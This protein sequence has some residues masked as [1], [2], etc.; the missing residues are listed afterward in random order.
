VVKRIRAQHN[1][2]LAVCLSIGT[3]GCVSRAVLVRLDPVCTL[4]AVGPC[5]V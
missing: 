2:V 1:L 3:S 5:M 4:S